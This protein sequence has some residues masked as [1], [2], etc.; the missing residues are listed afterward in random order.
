MM[1]AGRLRRSLFLLLPLLAGCG[2]ELGV[3]DSAKSPDQHY[4]A[5]LR[6]YE[7]R[8]LGGAHVRYELNDA[9]GTRVFYQNDA[10]EETTV[11]FAVIGWSPDS[12]RVAAGL[13]NCWG[14]GL[15]VAGYDVV[16][17]SQLQDA[18]AKGLV[19]T[20][21]MAR[22]SGWRSYEWMPASTQHKPD[23]LEYAV[24][25]EGK[26]AYFAAKAAR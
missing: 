10:T 21:I 7:T 23:P 16:Q 3:E 22:Y 20:A 2:R 14:R 11:C 4:E 15:V 19:R 12:S 9:K 8:P 13:R 6:L 5:V 18:E 24:T 25:D 1:D 17:Q 26:S